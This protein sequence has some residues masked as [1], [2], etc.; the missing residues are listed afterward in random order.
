M[1]VCGVDRYDQEQCSLWYNKEATFGL[2]NHIEEQMLLWPD[3]RRKNLLT[4][5]GIWK[6]KDHLWEWVM[7]LHQGVLSEDR[8]SVSKIYQHQPWSMEKW[9]VGVKV[10]HSVDKRK[11]V[12]IKK[13][14]VNS[15][16]IKVEF[17]RQST[18]I[19][20]VNSKETP[21]L[22]LMEK[23]VKYCLCR[24]G[25]AVTLKAVGC[26]PRCVS[27]PLTHQSL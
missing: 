17:N 26:G 21:K 27:E 14:M 6:G 5:K 10:A 24:S 4:I 1:S 20:K 9:G 16:F 22:L 8:Q 15:G 3:Y 18:L 2:Y 13:W 25:I 11:K 12:K 23:K 7:F 19:P